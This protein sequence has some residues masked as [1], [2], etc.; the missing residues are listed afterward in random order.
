MFICASLTVFFLGIFLD[1]DAEDRRVNERVAT[2]ERVSFDTN[3]FWSDAHHRH[4][5]VRLEDRAQHIEE[6]MEGFQRALM[7]TDGL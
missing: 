6:A 7:T 1:P 3:T 4:A 2:L 5:V